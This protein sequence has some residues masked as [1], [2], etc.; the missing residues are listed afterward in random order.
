[1]FDCVLFPAF[2]S[3]TKFFEI[4]V[5]NF[6]FLRPKSVFPHRNSSRADIVVLRIPC[7]TESMVVGRYQGW[8]W[9]FVR[10]FVFGDHIC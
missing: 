3:A 2:S 6:T 9:L 8:R 1:M 4:F 5:N 10:L 7:D